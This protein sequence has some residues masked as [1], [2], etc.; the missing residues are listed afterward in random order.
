M[1]V[2]W[3]TAATTSPRD[4]CARGGGRQR[5]STR[6][7]LNCHLRPDSLLALPLAL[8]PGRAAGVSVGATHHVDDLLLGRLRVGQARLFGDICP[9]QERSL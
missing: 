5:L 6:G 4:T 7:Q 3:S 1:P 2:T 8:G 9:Q